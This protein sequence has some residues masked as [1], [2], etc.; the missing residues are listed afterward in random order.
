MAK[1]D[2]VIGFDADDTLWHNETIFE[3]VHERYR[4]LLA[5]YHD[6]ETVERTLGPNDTERTWYKQNPPLPK[7]KWSLR[8]N[9]NYEQTGLLVSLSYVANN[10][11]Q[12]MRN[13][14]EKSKRSIQKAKTEGPAAYVRVRMIRVPARRP[15]SSR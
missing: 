10:R 9:N 13:F 15:S 7:V 14:Y 12:L 4:A 3:R 6:A 1:R 2:L 11:R 5:R 8:N